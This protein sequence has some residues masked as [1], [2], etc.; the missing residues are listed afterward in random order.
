MTEKYIISY[1]HG[2]SGM[3]TAI[4]S[5]KGEVKGF[6]VE[7]YKLYHPEKGAA[8]QDP[9]DWWDALC[10]TTKE[11]LDQNL[12]PKEKIVACVSSN[13]M[14]GTIPINKNGEVL[15]NCLTWMDTRGAPMVKKLCGG[16]IEISGYGVTNLLK[17]IPRTCGAP[18]LSGKDIIGHILWFKEKHPDIYEKTWKFLDCKDYLNYKL[19]NKVVTSYDCAILTWLM[20]TQDPQNIHYDPGLLEKSKIDGVK[21]PDLQPSSHVIGDLT[22]EAAKEL[23]LNTDIKV[24]LGAGDMGTAAIGSGAVLDNQAHICI[25]SSSWIIAHTPLRNVDIFNMVT[26]LP[27]A[28]EGKYVGLGEQEAAGINLTWLRDNVL[29]HKDELLQDEE[30]PDVYKIFDKMVANVEPG[31]NNLIFTPWMYGERSPIEDHTIRGGLYNVSLDTN[32][33]HIIRAIFEGVAFNSKWLLK[34]IEKLVEVKKLDPITLVGGG[35]ISDVW[36]Q[37]YADILDRTIMQVNNPKHSNSIGAAFIASVALGYIKWEDIPN[38]IK[39]NKVFKPRQEYR[40]TYDK[41]FEQF[42]NIYKNNHKMYRKLNKFEG[43]H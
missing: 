10:K 23:N 22:S 7:E 1:D 29:Y 13:Q 32:R 27:S 37:I 41:L 15:H 21:L 4:V 18:G 6:S 19:T 11:L 8:E 39:I 36:C 40:D 9:K 30:V 25:G 3:K 31:A 16:L 35:A 28:I 33:E 14:D 43:E 26:C 34:Y 24:V 42:K 2:T 20:N 12:V 5:E 17:W 38:L